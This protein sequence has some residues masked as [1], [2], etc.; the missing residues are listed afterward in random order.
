MG[1]V[2]VKSWMTRNV[3]TVTPDTSIM[4][5]RRLLE[6]YDIRHLPVVDDG[7]V[8]GMVSSRDLR[9]G[10]RVLSAALATLQSDLADGRFRPVSSIM[11]TPARTVRPDDLIAMATALM[12]GARVG[13]V[14]VVEGDRL[15]GVLSV[16]DCLR[17]YLA[18]AREQARGTSR[19]PAVEDDPDLWWRLP[20]PSGDVR[21]GRSARPRRVAV[22]PSAGQ[23]EHESERK[24]G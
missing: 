18:S 22:S 3:I 12:L 6:A 21:P 8:V 16:V 14:P 23:P 1:S 13:A 2:Q 19:H 4:N 20:M 24:A 11:S 7:R 5:A 15:V 9:C 10:D 17:A